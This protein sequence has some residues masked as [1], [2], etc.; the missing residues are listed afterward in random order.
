[1]GILDKSNNQVYVI[2]SDGMMN[3]KFPVTGSTLFMMDDINN[4]SY[5]EIVVG[6]PFGKIFSYTVK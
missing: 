3:D 2:E 1:M 5:P 4:D 6:N